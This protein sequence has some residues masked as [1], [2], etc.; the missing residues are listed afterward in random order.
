MLLVGLYHRSA[1]GLETPFSILSSTHPNVGDGS[2]SANTWYPPIVGH[3]PPQT[4]EETCTSW[5]FLLHLQWDL[6]TRSSPH[7][8]PSKTNGVLDLLKVKASLW[9]MACSLRKFHL[10]RRKY[11]SSQ[12]VYHLSYLPPLL[13]DWSYLHNSPRIMGHSHHHWY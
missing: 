10:E 9:A 6:L 5:D 11:S 1:S 8:W 4:F 7:A 13:H 3:Q 2:H 12:D